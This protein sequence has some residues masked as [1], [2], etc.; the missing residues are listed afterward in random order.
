MPNNAVFDVAV[1]GRF[2]ADY[3]VEALLEDGSAANLYTTFPYTK[4]PTIPRERIHSHLISELVFRAGRFLPF[5]NKTN[6]LKMTSFGKWLALNLPTNEASHFIGWSSF[7]LELLRKHRYATTILE[8]DS[9]HIVSQMKA[10][11][12][13]YHRVGLPFEPD[14]FVVERELEEYSLSHYLFVLSEN[15]KQSFVDEGHD[16]SRIFVTPLGVDLKTFRPNFSRQRGR[17]LKVIYFGALS[18]RKGIHTL[19]EATQ[20]FKKS[21]LELVLVGEIESGYD[22]ILRRY[23]HAMI[24]PSLSHTKL[25]ELAREMDVFAFP[26]IEDGFGQTT[27]QAMASGLVSLVSSSAGSS[28]CIESGVDGFVLPPHDANPWQEKLRWAIDHPNEISAIKKRAADK[29]SQFSWKNYQHHLRHSLAAL[30][31]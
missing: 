22:K 11:N 31:K 28:D 24:L 17:A 23:T 14:S 12:D 3:M 8:R 13:E 1:G 2:H 25:S 10:L 26:S 27:V 21:E 5:E 4:F 29:A 16:P 15:A 19:L 18:V 20:G 9:T 6:H 7:A 30:P